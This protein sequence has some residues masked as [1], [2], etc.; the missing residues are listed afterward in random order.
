[1]FQT[2]GVAAF[3]ARRRACKVA[4]DLCRELRPGEPILGESIC[5]NEDDRYVVRVFCGQR[6]E[7][8]AQMGPPWRECLI[9]SVKKGSNLA[10]LITEDAAYRP[11][12]R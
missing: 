9:V 11:T 7:A 6:A 1:M 8:R 3:R 4:G 5:A 12:I 10:E 2:L